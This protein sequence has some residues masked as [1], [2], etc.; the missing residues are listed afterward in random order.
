VG[1]GKVALDFRLLLLETSTAL[2]AHHH[3]PHKERLTNSH[4]L[5][6]ESWGLAGRDGN[7]ARRMAESKSC[8]APELHSIPPTHSGIASKT[9]AHQI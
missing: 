9:P 6:L 1:W 3:D 5:D 7:L 2:P 8:L 4:S